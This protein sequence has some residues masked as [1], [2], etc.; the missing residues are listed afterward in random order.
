M[1]KALTALLA[2][3]VASPAL[4]H[5]DSSAHLHGTDG[6]VWLALA[7]AGGIASLFLFRN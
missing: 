4:A 5:A 1:T 3:A 6:A 2:A 7:V